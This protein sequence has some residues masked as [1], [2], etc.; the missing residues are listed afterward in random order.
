MIGLIGRLEE[1]GDRFG[2]TSE[3]KMKK[4]LRKEWQP[5]VEVRGAIQLGL[6][7]AHPTCY[8]WAEPLGNNPSPL[9][10]IKI[11]PANKL[12]FMGR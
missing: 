6:P 4:K 11:G 2:R 5:R 1:S 3:K 12:L 7:R 10:N 8:I 9:N